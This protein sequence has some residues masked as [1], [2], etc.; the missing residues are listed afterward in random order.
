MDQLTSQSL[1]PARKHVISS[2]PIKSHLATVSGDYF[3]IVNVDSKQPWLTI[4]DV[5]YL[6][7]QAASKLIADPLRICCVGS[8][9]VVCG[10][11]DVTVVMVTIG[12]DGGTLA[13]ALGR[14][15]SSS[16]VVFKDASLSVSEQ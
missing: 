3:A 14:G 11:D 7:N 12:H 10:L 15:Q 6:T 1:P 5:A 13:A 4:W 2:Q 9:V 8:Y 16:E